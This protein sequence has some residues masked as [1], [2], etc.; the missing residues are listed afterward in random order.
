MSEKFIDYEKCKDTYMKLQNIFAN[1]LLEKER[2]FTR[3]LPSA[4]RYDKD[5]VQSTI[6]GNPLESFVISVED[7]ELDA[8]IARY[9]Q[10]LKDW[11]MLLGIKERELRNSKSMLDR[12]YVCRFLDGH[13]IKRI[14][15][16]LNYSRPQIYRKLSQ[17]NKKLRQNE[18][19]TM[20]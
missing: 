7:K 3:T 17:I 16:I 18:T 10:N 4:I 2:L 6:D 12:I 14:C 11:Q 9:R 8:R 13:S 5:K 20:L 1:A 19:D 15:A